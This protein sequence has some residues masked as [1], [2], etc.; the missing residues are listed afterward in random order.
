MISDTGSPPNKPGGRSPYARDTAA[1]TGERGARG[2]KGCAGKAIKFSANLDV[3]LP[4]Q[5]VL[6]TPAQGS[7]LPNT[8]HCY[9]RLP[10]M[11]GTHI[12]FTFGLGC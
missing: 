10:L 1:G 7:Y 9:E 12:A 4:Q 6:L 5:R 3:R 11:W 2:L 8:A